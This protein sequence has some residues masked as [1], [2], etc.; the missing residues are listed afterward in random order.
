M[1]DSNGGVALAGPET[2]PGDES[3]NGHVY[4]WERRLLKKVLAALGNPPVSG[5]LWNGEEVRPTD[6]PAATRLRF[7]RRKALLKSLLDPELYFGDEY[8]AGRID[9]EGDLVRFIEQAFNRPGAPQDPRSAL[10]R[11]HRNS[12]TR[13]RANIFHH[14]DV[15]ND[16]FKLWLD[17]QMVY[18]CAY[19]ADPAMSLEAAQVAK[20]DH[21]C[22]K[23][24]LRPGERVVEAGCGWGSLARHMASRYGVKVDAFNIS[25]EQIA[26]ARDRAR[27]EGLDRLVTYH[28]ADYRDIRGTYDAFVSVGMLEHVGIENYA[29]LGSIIDRCLTPKG[30]GLIHTI[31]LHRPMRFNRWLE[32]R[33]F[34]GA[35]PPALSELMTVLEPYDLT[36]L[37]VEN[38]RNHYAQ[39]LR[40]WLARFENAVEEI[41]AMFDERFVRLWRFYLAG[42]L[43]AYTSGWMQ[44]F[45]VLFN[46]RTNDDVPWNRAHLYQTNAGGT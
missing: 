1:S 35:E 15:S 30:R 9:I 33:I 40:H 25:H 13:S 26:Y 2:P 37:D 12:L 27:R 14:Y 29:N 3:R 5:I 46:R 22:R 42:S 18:T 21:V 11:R 6:R 20:M 41:G 36:V 38:L 39:T 10:R 34:P 23:L 43:A 44:L 19:F 31:G 4:A 28:E 7:H 32:A 24:R 17:D 45:Q 8:A 16:F